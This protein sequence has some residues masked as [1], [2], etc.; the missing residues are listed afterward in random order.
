MCKNQKNLHNFLY[1]CSIISI[2]KRLIK[3]I[4][5]NL[6]LSLCELAIRQKL[7]SPLRLYVYLKSIC[8]G[9]IRLDGSLK[10]QIAQELNVTGR[11]VNNLL[12]ELQVR[13]WVGHNPE[14]GYYFVRG[15]DWVRAKENLRGRRGVW[16]DVSKDL[17]NKQRF[18][19]FVSG[20]LI[21]QMANVSKYKM[22]ER[23][24]QGPE[25]TK[26]SSNHRS[27]TIVPS[28]FPVACKAVSK[29]LGV[30]S[31]TASL[32]KEQ[33]AEYGFIDVKKQWQR[34]A[35]AGDPKVKDADFASSY[36]ASHPEEAHRVRIREG[37]VYLQ[38]TDLVLACLNYTKKWRP[39]SHSKRA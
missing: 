3:N 30:A 29:M 36:K 4:K 25:H 26:G 16:V 24:K 35:L 13:N 21:G 15:F 22:R 7:V 6:P 1:L 5:I 38:E 12:K 18:T 28:H 27:C 23:E 9:Q 31:S 11:T 19:A 8:H 33:A 37:K 34:L 14:S 32:M 39:R 20:A 10:N 17:Q 2:L